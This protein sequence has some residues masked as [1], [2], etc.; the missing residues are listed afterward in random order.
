MKENEHL[1]NSCSREEFCNGEVIIRYRKINND[2]G[3]IIACD[4]YNPKLI[5]EEQE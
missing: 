4:H 3:I 2:E 1:C 5:L